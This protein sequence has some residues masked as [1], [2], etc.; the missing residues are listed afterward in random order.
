[1]A[2][3]K[4][5]V[6]D[7]RGNFILKVG[8]VK[9]EK[10][11]FKMRIGNNPED[12]DNLR[13]QILEDCGEKAELQSIWAYF[14][15]EITALTP[16]CKFKSKNKGSWVDLQRANIDQL[17]NWKEIF[18]E[19]AMGG[20]LFAEVSVASDRTFKDGF[21]N[22]FNFRVSLDGSHEFALNM[23]TFLVKA[24][25]VQI[26]EKLLLNIIKKFKEFDFFFEFDTLENLD[27]SVSESLLLDDSRAE[28][29]HVDYLVNH[30]KKMTS[31]LGDPKELSGMI[32]KGV[33]VIIFMNRNMYFNLEIKGEDAISFLEG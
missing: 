6:D 14:A 26:H 12:V 30:I 5:K 25:H 9:E 16:E 1:M 27:K 11:Y 13:N 33:R 20:E 19:N 15:G 2:D 32:E 17:K 24:K 21:Y 7:I 29:G 28:N 23:G 10:T 18:P 8:E 31:K 4:A 3:S 22:S